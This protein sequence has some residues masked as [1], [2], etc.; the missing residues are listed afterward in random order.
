MYNKGNLSFIIV[1]GRKWLPTQP[2]LNSEF[3]SYYTKFVSKI[4]RPVVVRQ[5]SLITIIRRLVFQLDQTISPFKI[6]HLIVFISDTNNYDCSSEINFK[7]PLPHKG[8][9]LIPKWTFGWNKVVNV[10]FQNFEQRGKNW[11][12]L[13]SMKNSWLPTH[14]GISGVTFPLIWSLPLPFRILYTC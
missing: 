9:L 13:H 12:Y 11:K 14:Q 5:C 7:R 8:L 4:L 2:V 6:V 1:V 10:I 3:S